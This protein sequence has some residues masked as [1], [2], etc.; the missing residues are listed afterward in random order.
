LRVAGGC[1]DAVDVIENSVSHP[2]LDE[3][4]ARLHDT[5]NLVVAG[6]DDE[7]GSIVREGTAPGG[8]ELSGVAPSIGVAGR[9]TA[10]EEP[11]N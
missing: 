6:I 4:I 1:A 5:A 9:I 8:A 7:E 10:P 2:V 3:V 11:R